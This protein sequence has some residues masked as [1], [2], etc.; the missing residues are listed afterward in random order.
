MVS[1]LNPYCNFIDVSMKDGLTL[2]SNA[3]EKFESLLVGDQH[4][5]LSP[6]KNDFQL[7]K[8]NLMRLSKKF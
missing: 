5:S 1:Y 4:V 2:L 6:G 3:T 7:L 8:D